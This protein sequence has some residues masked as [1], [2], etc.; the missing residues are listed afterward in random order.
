[1]TR[2]AMHK[3]ATDHWTY[4]DYLKLPD[5]GPRCEIIEGE[6]LMTPA[7]SWKHQDVLGHLY[8]LL[9]TFVE[10]RGLGKVVLAPFDVILAKDTV[11]QPD[12]LVVVREQGAPVKNR[13]LFEAPDLA[14]EVLSPS[15]EDRDRDRKMRAYARH[16]VREYWIADPRARRIEVYVLEG[17]RLVKKAD[18]ESGEVSSLAVL[19]GFSAKLDDVFKA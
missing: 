12:V 11:V 6:L 5:D 10:G 18:H 9:L 14:V 4:E 19:P 16:G 1:M 8:V 7:P 15:T 13:G 17:R 3:P 2:T